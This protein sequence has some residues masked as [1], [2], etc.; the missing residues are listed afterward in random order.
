MAFLLDLVFI[1]VKIYFLRQLT[2]FALLFLTFSLKGQKNLRNEL[3]SLKKVLRQSTYYDSSMVFENGQKA[4]AIA[5]KLKDPAEEATIYQYY[6]NFYY[7]SY[8][9]KKAH[10]NYAKSIEIAQ[11]NNNNKLVNS[12]KIR[13][14][15]LESDND[16]LSA[17]KE[18]HRLLNEAIKYNYIENT[19]EIYNGLGN[20]YDT[21]QMKDEALKYYLKGLRIAEKQDK[22]YHQAMM[23]NNIGLIK[24]NNQQVKEAE[25]DFV[26]AVKN[27]ENLNEDRLSFNLNNNLGLVNKELKDYKQSIK[28]YHN[29]LNSAK[30]L[31][32]PLGR[33]VAYINLGD[34]YYQNKEYQFALNYIDSAARLMR[35]FEQWDY[36]GMSL[37]VR[38]S[39]YKDLGQ[40]NDAKSIIDSLFNLHR[41]FPNA[42]NIMLGH[43]ILASIYEK[44]HNFKLAYEHSN[45][46]HEMNDSISDMA[47]KDKFAQL[48]V[49]Y[50]KE[51]VETEL[52]S[53]RSK[54]TILSKENE[55]KQA[56]I[57]SVFTVSF[58]VLIFGIGLIYIRH[59]LLTRKQQQH[60]TQKLI[61]NIDEERSRISKDLHDDIGQSLSVIKSK[62]NLFNK[63]QITDLSGMDNE[64]GEV[65][66]QTRSI[67]H[68]LHPSFIH[69]LGLERSLDSLT[70][71]T[72]KNTEIICS[73]D[74]RCKLESLT[75]L[76]Q[77][78]IYRIMQEC[79]NNTIK[80]ADA[81]ALK[82][83]IKENAGS[84]IIKY[85]DNG[86]GMDEK[87]SNAEGIGMMTIKERAIKINAKLNYQTLV[88]KGF[89]LVITINKNSQ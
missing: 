36:Y 2:F 71:K 14:A 41:T 8:D 60:F 21:R 86:K 22:K 7:F 72:Q 55:L 42:N 64:V 84:Y 73:L 40:L 75:L 85:Q 77:T 74:V 69:K 19:I 46:Y 11:K 6:G 57:R 1:F 59:V 50:G 47:S 12:T 35:S 25:K 4:I 10:S 15:F 30:K 88:G 79:I 31:G 81:T 65:I 28:Y 20:I 56:K 45:R 48:Q 26:E 3:D 44:Q 52:E 29:T 39:I 63:G 34:S 23:L 54:N 87:D 80:H 68:F 76:E 43:E 61:E 49:I 24:F 16:L 51:K 27:I 17:E 58:A 33:G 32:F 5:R 83:S 62:L 89:T 37:L 66:N 13:L 9:L 82:I 67:S 70:E 53:E 78:Q 18:F 38:A